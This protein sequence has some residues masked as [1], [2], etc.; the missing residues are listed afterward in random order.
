MKKILI[1]GEAVIIA[2]LL[3]NLFEDQNDLTAL[4]PAMFL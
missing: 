1:D 2:G 4:T 3:R